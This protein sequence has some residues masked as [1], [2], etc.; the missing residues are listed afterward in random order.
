MLRPGF[1]NTLPTPLTNLI[2]RE[3]DI[4]AL[5]HLLTQDDKPIRLL[6]LTGAAGSGKTRLAIHLGN[7]VAPAY[8]D[9]VGWVDLSLIVDE[10]LIGQ[11]VANALQIAIKPKEEV[12]TTLVQHLEFRRFLLIIDN[13][14]H[15]IDGCAELVQRLLSTCPQLQIL[16]TSRESLKIPGERIWLTPLLSVPRRGTEPPFAEI[17]DYPGIRLWVERAT[18]AFPEFRL[19]PENAPA[20]VRV[21]QRLDGMPLA[22]ELAAARVKVLSVEQIA[23]RLDDRFRLL[24]ADMRT[25]L[26]R[27]QTL[28]ATVD[29]SYTLLSESER[30]LLQYLSVFVGGCALDAVEY[31]VGDE[32]AFADD[33]AL[34][35][36]TRLVEKSL[37]VVERIEQRAR[38]HLLETIR[39]Y[40]LEKLRDGGREVDMRRRHRDWFLQ[41]AETIYPRTGSEQQRNWL[42][43]MDA[44]YENFQ[45]AIEWSAQEPGEA[46]IG[47]RLACLMRQYWDRKGYLHEAR[48]Y[49]PRLL[50]HTENS[51]PTATRAEALNFL[52][53]FTLLHGDAPAAT[54]FYEDALAIGEAL[55]DMSAIAL[56]CS[57]LVFVLAGS[58]DPHKAEPYIQQGLDAARLIN[59]SVRIYSIL[60][61]ASWLALAE[62]DY[63]RSHDL[64]AESLH[65]MRAGKDL[66]LTGAALWRLGHLCWLEHNNPESL[67]AFQESLTV[68]RTLNNLRGVAYAIDG[69]AWAAAA[70]GNH[71]LAARLFGAA[72]RQ[73]SAMQTHFHPLEQ[74]A[75]DAA[76]A[77]ARAG[78]D[79]AA[80]AAAWEEGRQLSLAD[81]AEIAA[82]LVIAG[83]PATQQIAPP[84]TAPLKLYGLGS[85]RVVLDG[86]TIAA[87]DWTYSRARDLL[88]YLATEGAASREEIGLVFWPDAS[89]EQLR[90]NL[91]VTLHH[92]RKALGHSEW[93]IFDKENYRFNRSL[94]YWYDVEAF[95]A[96]HQ[97]AQ[98]NATSIPL[99][100]QALALYTGEFLADAS[101]GEWYLPL[102]ERLA[103]QHTEMLFA[104]ARLHQAGG[105]HHLAVALYR[106]AISHNPYLESAY[107]ELME[108]LAQMGERAQA[109]RVYTDLVRVMEDEFAAPPAKETQAVYEHLRRG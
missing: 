58:G 89:P 73:F 90:R 50:A 13:C 84:A 107:R 60:F 101:V 106:Q 104:L 56:A 100:Q 74:P 59:D 15:L 51:A 83:E 39:Q 62:G 99:L 94:G 97:Q 10:R 28:R 66:N 81:A 71:S 31:L 7:V 17:Q 1:E 16:A 11:A 47:L 92:L 40:G 69:V 82:A 3:Q 54:T 43:E 33:T 53:F 6:T 42:V 108:C 87:T 95:S 21:C 8:P 86:R 78:L 25:V 37:V 20:V 29:W 35:V 91:G 9:G 46:G 64:L 93:I 105:D 96:L 49:L 55:Q 22:I 19:T 27:N 34:D 32:P 30:V 45:A 24:K 103:Q 61:Y 70:A 65:L 75:H 48:F 98:P 38:Y 57:G 12:T 4:D 14:E 2:G 76:V 52:G 80:F 23:A 109:L 41:R 79:P 26:P 67:A 102:R 88:F 63:P 72:D 44:E 5:R 68:R 77:L 36:L 18:A 85:G